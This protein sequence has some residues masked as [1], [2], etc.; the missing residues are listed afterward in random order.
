[1][2]YNKLYFVYSKF[3][4]I[5]KFVLISLILSVNLNYFFTDQYNNY[6]NVAYAFDKN[7]EYITHVSMKSIML[8]Q[9]P[10]TFINFYLL[11]SNLTSKQKSI[12]DRIKFEHKNC[13]IKYFD[14][15]DKF[16]NFSIPLNIWSTAIY[17][18]ICLQ[19]LL[20]NEKK[21]LYLDTDTLVYKDLTKIYNYKIEQ[22][23]YVGML[24]NKGKTYFNQYN[25]SFN[26][27]INSG[28]LLCNLEEL[29][30]E[31]VTKKYL[32]FFEKFKAKIV[33]PLNDGLNFVS[34]GKKGFFNPEFVTIGFCNE[35][36]SFNY[37]KNM[38]ITINNTEVVESY[39]DPYI[40]HFILY[41]KP[42]KGIPNNNIH[43]CIDPIV[44]FYEMAKKTS[45][46]YEILEKFLIK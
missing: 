38:N 12:I 13:E 16:K 33:F 41:V 27:Y 5:S 9:R 7:Y 43:I 18:R 8:S 42:W 32:D 17:Y 4:F 39:K 29:R 20:P 26:I 23:Y 28:V 45:L 24:E 10:T 44:R 2:F 14:M 37:Y 21:I 19:D 25:T 11:V 31:N 40:Y 30:R 15:G 35:T 46:Y 1:M 36:E 6:I 3:I 22:N 34:K